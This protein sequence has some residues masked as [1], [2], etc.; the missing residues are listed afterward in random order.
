M[1]AREA[2]IAGRSG[3]SRPPKQTSPSSTQGNTQQDREQKAF[4]AG[5]QERQREQTIRN[6]GIAGLPQDEREQARSIA[7]ET[8]KDPYNTLTN[9]EKENLPSF[10]KKKGKVDA[11]FEGI[12]DFYTEYGGVYGAVGNF[13][14]TPFRMIAEP[15]PETFRDPKS[16]ATL[17]LLFDRKGQKFKEQYLKD[18]GDILSEAYADDPTKDVRGLS[19][20]DFFD[21]QLQEGAFASEQGILGA[22]SQRINFPAEF[23]TGEKGLNPYGAGGMP[24]TS[25]DL[26]NLAGLAV[27]P[28]MQGNNP[29]LVK[30]IFNARMELDRMGKNP[31]TGESQGQPQ[32]IPSIPGIP[33]LPVPR[34]GPIPPD[35]YP[36]PGQPP[37][38]PGPGLPPGFPPNFMPFPGQPPYGSKFERPRPYNYFAQSPQYRFRGIPSVNTDAF[39]E[40]LRNKFGV[41]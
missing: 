33:S 15:T 3:G 22:G 6:E 1:S 11:I 4:D 5:Q 26:A 25:G 41:A 35:S 17:K 19:D 32:G 34:P 12:K 20:S 2:Y 24:Q 16:L 37:F 21:E 7:E 13:L 10:E 30:M 14:M 31:M 18:H 8:G 9:E 39:N 36:L 29:E 27:T 40:E 23:Y 28:E 38:M